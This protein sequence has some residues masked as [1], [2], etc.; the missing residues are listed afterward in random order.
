MHGENDCVASTK[1][2]VNVVSANQ[3]CCSDNFK[4][5]DN[6]MDGYHKYKH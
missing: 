6:N 1:R 2:F 3:N 5:Y 4:C